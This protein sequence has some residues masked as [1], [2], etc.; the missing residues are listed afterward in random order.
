MVNIKSK[1]ITGSFVCWTLMFLFLVLFSMCKSSEKT[2]AEE[3]EKEE[4]AATEILSVEKLIP[5]FG[6]TTGTHSGIFDLSQSQEEL[7]I[8]YNFYISEI[9]EFDEEIG[10]DMAPKIQKFYEEFKTPDR[11]A[12]RVYV[13]GSGEEPWRQY[14]F[15]VV[16]RKLVEQTE[17]TNLLAIEFLRTVEELKYYE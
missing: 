2:E 15:F 13:P 9:S 6:D 5:I 3:V 16:T 4:K 10:T 8:S 14:V 1:K 17:W 12:F 11:V 7:L